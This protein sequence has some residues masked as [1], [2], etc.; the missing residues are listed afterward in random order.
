MSAFDGLAAVVLDVEQS[1]L[2]DLAKVTATARMPRP[3]P[4]TFAITG[5]ARRIVVA[6]IR[7][8]M[9]SACQRSA[10]PVRF[11][12]VFPLAAR[13]CCGIAERPFAPGKKTT[14]AE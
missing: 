1:V 11:G 12:G 6:T 14:L 5:G 2:A 3:H 4:V 7:R 10:S 13:A 9:S 8:R